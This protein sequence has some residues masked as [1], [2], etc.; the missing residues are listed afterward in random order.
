MAAH[1]P[2]RV[3]AAS[4]V[5]TIAACSGSSKETT[6]TKPPGPFVQRWTVIRSVDDCRALE[7]ENSC[8]KNATCNPPPPQ[9]I[10]CPEG[11]GPDGHVVVAELP[12]HSCA[13]VPVGCNELACAAVKTACPMPFGQELPI[14]RWEVMREAS[15]ECIARARGA[16]PV[17]V[18]CPF[19]DPQT[20]AP[21]SVIMRADAKA[22]CFADAREQ[23]KM[24]VPCPDTVKP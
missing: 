19:P 4:V 5:V 18:A 22:P 23:M 12:D 1:R 15:G 16:D 3:F 17:K 9:A 8:P 21:S 10:A 7:T 14:L 6:G 11:S 20:G 24:E 13:I 2:R